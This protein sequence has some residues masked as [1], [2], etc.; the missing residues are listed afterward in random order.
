[1]LFWP[2]S[3]SA[4]MCSIDTYYTGG[5]VFVDWLLTFLVITYEK[6]AAHP[7]L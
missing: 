7:G 4:G 2:Q 1:M 6:A 5:V 3:H